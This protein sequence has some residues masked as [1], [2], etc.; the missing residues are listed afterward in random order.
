MSVSLTAWFAFRPFAALLED[1]AAA[2]VDAMPPAKAKVAATAKA[3][4]TCFMIS[5]LHSFALAK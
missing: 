2:G 4:R 1:A 3:P 5:S